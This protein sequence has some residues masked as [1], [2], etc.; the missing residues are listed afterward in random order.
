MFLSPFLVLSGFA[1]GFSGCLPDAIPESARK[2]LVN[3]AETYGVGLWV[4]DWPAG[5]AA[6]ALVKIVIQDGDTLKVADLASKLSGLPSSTVSALVPL[7]SS[8]CILRRG[9][10]SWN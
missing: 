9:V 6:A 1:S 8:V 3:G 2:D 7:Q 10:T 4:N 5:H